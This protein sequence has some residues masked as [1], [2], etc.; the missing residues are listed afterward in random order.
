MGDRSWA[1]I[2]LDGILAPKVAAG[3]LFRL[4]LGER[5]AEAVGLQVGVLPNDDVTGV[6]RHVTRVIRAADVQ[7]VNAVAAVAPLVGANARGQR[8]GDHRVTAGSAGDR[9]EPAARIR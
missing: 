5:L 4:S 7:H 2:P 3:L 1:S 6:C 9:R 8:A